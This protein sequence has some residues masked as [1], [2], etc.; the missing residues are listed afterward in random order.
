VKSVPGCFVAMAPSLIGSPVA[1]W[2]VPAP[3]LGP[4]VDSGVVL[5]VLFELQAASAVDATSTTASRAIMPFL[6]MALP[7]SIE[8]DLR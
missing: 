1:F 3:H 8:I 4:V 2:P 7:P 5:V 6:R